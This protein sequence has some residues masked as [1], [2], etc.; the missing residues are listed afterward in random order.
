MERNS[1]EQL[2]KELY[3]Y[4]VSLRTNTLSS[5]LSVQGDSECIVA[6]FSTQRNMTFVGLEIY[7]YS[8]QTRLIAGQH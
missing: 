4:K 1:L 8:E 6:F 2:K 3:F 5:N 7:H